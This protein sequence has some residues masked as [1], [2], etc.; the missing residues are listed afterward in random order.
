MLCYDVF[1][2]DF[3]LNK[4]NSLRDLPSNFPVTK[5][6]SL[7]TNILLKPEISGLFP[8]EM[9]LDEANSMNLDSS[10][11]QVQRDIALMVQLEHEVKSK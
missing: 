3:Q 6:R 9:L 4:I 7:A 11:S 8:L 1:N 5:S 2:A 10:I